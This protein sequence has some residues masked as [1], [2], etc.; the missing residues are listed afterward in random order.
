MFGP[1]IRVDD[2]GLDA[3]GWVSD[4]EPF[5]SPEGT[6]EPDLLFLGVLQEQPPSIAKWDT[7]LADG[8]T[9][10]IGGTDAHQNVLALELRDGDRMDSYRRMMRWFSNV[11]WVEG[12]TPADYDA[13]VAA[14]RVWV[15]FEI[16]G[17]PAGFDFSLEGAT[18]TAT[19]PALSPGSPQGLE[20]PDIAVTV[21]KDGEPFATECGSWEVEPGVYRARIDITPH[22][23]RPF[24]GDDPDRWLVPYPWVYTNAVRR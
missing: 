24:L 12:D 11:L 23:L 6:G 20:S 2:L 19:C 1:D 7:L 9:V 4:I 21:F 18:L 14:G 17:L 22:H 16:L 15:V 5:T 13:A 8:P 3:F 10:G